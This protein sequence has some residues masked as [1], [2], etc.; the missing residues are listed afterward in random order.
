MQKVISIA[1]VLTSAVLIGLLVAFLNPTGLLMPE[2][3][4]MML[5][6][7]F[8]VAFMAFLGF[9]WKERAADEREHA[10]QLA[11][12]RISFFV[13]S[14]VLTV[15]ILFQALRHDIDPWMVGALILMI[16]AKLFSRMYARATR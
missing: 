1:E 13:G 7:L 12:G 5:L 9:F 4:E 16:L 3:S 11:A 2:S 15:G 8:A 6:V 14:T 10:H